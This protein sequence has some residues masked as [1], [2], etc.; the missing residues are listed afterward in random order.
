V[1]GFPPF[2]CVKK[3]NQYESAAAKLEVTVSYP[4]GVTFTRDGRC[5]LVADSC[6]DCVSKFCAANGAFIARVATR[7]ANGIYCPTD[8][9]LCEDGK[10]ILVAQ[11]GTYGSI[12]GSVVCVGEDG[13]TVKNII[14]P[15]PGDGCVQAPCSFSYSVTLGVVV[16]TRK[17]MV[18]LLGDAWMSS[19]RRAWLSAMCMR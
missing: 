16:K 2:A 1:H 5:I 3:I 14:I 19:S 6:N 11:G 13:V 7:A 10:S 18:F 8:V 12:D 15:C 17:G 9:L 4:C